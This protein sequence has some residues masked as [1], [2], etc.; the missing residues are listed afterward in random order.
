MRADT[1]DDQTF[2]LAMLDLVDEAE[3]VGRPECLVLLPTMAAA[4]PWPRRS[5]LAALPNG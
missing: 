5:R 4:G 3:R 1:P 2:Q